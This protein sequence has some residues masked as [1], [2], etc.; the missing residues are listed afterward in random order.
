MVRIDKGK[1]SRSG[2]GGCDWHGSAGQVWLVKGGGNF[3]WDGQG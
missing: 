3:G 1:V 2:S